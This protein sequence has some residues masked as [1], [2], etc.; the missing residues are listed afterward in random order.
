MMPCGKLKK[1]IMPKYFSYRRA[2][3]SM[4]PKECA[5]L[6]SE[7]RGALQ[8][9][10]TFLSFFFWG[11]FKQGRHGHVPQTRAEC[12]S[13]LKISSPGT[14]SQQLEFGGRRAG[15]SSGSTGT[16]CLETTAASPCLHLG[17]MVMPCSVVP[18]S[19][20]SMWASL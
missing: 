10:D 17:D 20:C 1:C 18:C 16:G 8:K 7:L 2:I 5:T 14:T 13:S 6:C 9:N 3:R 19:S 15:R 4:I 12:S 11:D